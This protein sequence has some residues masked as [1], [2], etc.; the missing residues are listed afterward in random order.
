MTKSL[1]WSA[2]NILIDV[3]EILNKEINTMENLPSPGCPRHAEL[4]IYSAFR[5]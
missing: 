1:N 5:Y 4:G 3:N 2:R